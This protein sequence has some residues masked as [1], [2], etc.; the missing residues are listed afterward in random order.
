MKQWS[1]FIY[2]M[3]LLPSIAEDTWREERPGSLDKRI[4]LIM[5]RGGIV[6]PRKAGR[7]NLWAGRLCEKG[8][9]Y[10]KHCK[11]PDLPDPYAGGR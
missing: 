7:N 9:F 11:E 3:V 8:T 2:S 1:N 4:E 5:C 6:H 10:L